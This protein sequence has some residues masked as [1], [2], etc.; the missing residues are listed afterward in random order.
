M[1]LKPLQASGQISDQTSD[2]ASGLPAQHAS[3]TIAV[4]LHQAGS[5]PGRVGQWLESQG[6]QLD[7]RKPPLGDPLPID[8]THYAGAVVFGGPMSAN[9]DDVYVHDEINWCGHCLKQ[10]IPFL[11]ICLGAQM[12]VRALGGS[13]T[14]HPEEHAEIG[15]Y[16]LH[17]TEAGNSLLPDWPGMIYQWHREGF[18]L[19]T[20]GTLLATADLFREQAFQVGPSAFGVQFHTELTEA[21]MRRWL[22]R[23]RDRLELPSAQQRHAHIEGRMMYDGLTRDWLGRFLTVW[24]ASD[25]RGNA[26]IQQHRTA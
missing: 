9:D 7:I 18:E 25:T 3:K 17:P 13:V 6:Y 26:E 4:V 10:E 11:G 16:P 8:L 2:Q 12:L 1:N 20:G 15:Y 22:V 5:S 21:M 24:L 19:P 23:G 14:A